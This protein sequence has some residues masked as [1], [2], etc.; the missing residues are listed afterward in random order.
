[1]AK[2]EGKKL[3]LLVDDDPAN[4]QMVHSILKD[5]YK[6]RVATSGAKALE[7]MKVEPAPDLILLDVMMP[8]MDGYQVCGQLKAAPETRDVPVIFLTGKTEVANETRGFQVG[9]VDYIHKPFSPPIVKARVG[10]HLLLRE[11]REQLAGQLLAINHELDLAREIQ[12]SILPR[13]TP[14]IEGLQIASRFL[15][16]SSVAGDFYDFIVADARHVGVLVADVTG[17][18]LPAALI[19]SMLKIALSAQTAHA[20]D[21]VQVLSGLNEALCGMFRQYFV[22]AIYVFVD[23]ERNTLCYAGAGHPPLL[24]F[25]KETGCASE[26]ME[27]GMMLGLF[28]AANYSA[29]QVSIA[30]GDRIVL[31]TDGIIEARSATDEEFGTERFKQFLETKRNLNAEEFV[32]AM[33]GELLRWSVSPAKLTQQDDI[34]MLAIDFK[35]KILH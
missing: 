6:I 11:A 28:P 8:E 17:H 20:S 34:T 13:E 25:S 10:T 19:A 30:S 27:N 4:I 12:M 9:A 35:G 14:R 7:L 21:P 24:L 1:M 26:I 18:G 5:E 3:L 29:V 15:P 23:M 32:E 2:T 33:V 22:T 31:Y 16:M